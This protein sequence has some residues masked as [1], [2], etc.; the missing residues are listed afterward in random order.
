MGQ[1]SLRP[2]SCKSQRQIIDPGTLGDNGFYLPFSDA[3]DLGADY[4]GQDN[5][6]TAT[7]FITTGAGQD[8]V[9][10]TP[11]KNYAVLTSGSNG[12]LVTTAVNPNSISSTV[13]VPANSKV[14]AEFTFVAGSSTPL[15]CSCCNYFTKKKKL[16][17]VTKVRVRLV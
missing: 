9:K 8:P 2:Q 1:G 16:C 12:N 3:S 7:N 14:Y 4:S 17:W 5:D 15:V 10:D 6:F 11:M 13:D